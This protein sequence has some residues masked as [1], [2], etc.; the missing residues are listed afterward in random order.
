MLGNELQ[1]KVNCDQKAV[2]L[3]RLEKIE[4]ETGIK[5]IAYHFSTELHSAHA[6]LFCLLSFNLILR[7]D[8]L[9]LSRVRE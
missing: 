1:R 8:L 5:K 3:I 2:D 9:Y 6:L 4:G 7:L